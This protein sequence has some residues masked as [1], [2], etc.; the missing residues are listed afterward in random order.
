[1]SD[2]QGDW[3]VESSLPGRQA[4]RN[5]WKVPPVLLCSTRQETIKNESKKSAPKSDYRRTSIGN[6][7]TPKMT[8]GT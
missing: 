4:A 5:V 1:M 8:K 2:M 3:M 6:S 7:T